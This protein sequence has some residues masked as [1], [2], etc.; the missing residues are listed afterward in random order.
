MYL[1]PP[2]TVAAS[3]PA[4]Y[5]NGEK[6]LSDP[7]TPLCFPEDDVAVV[8][9]ARVGHAMAGLGLLAPCFP[10]DDVAVVDRARVG[11][12]M[13]GLELLVPD[14]TLDLREAEAV[15]TTAAAVEATIVPSPL[16]DVKNEKMT[17]K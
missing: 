5:T 16:T 3:P 2:A 6:S 4:T 7:S 8:D 9:R 15:R 1:I 10:D 13:T 14:S 17:K 11:H 12:A